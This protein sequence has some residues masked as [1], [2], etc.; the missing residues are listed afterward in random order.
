M[1]F[2]LSAFSIMISGI[3]ILTLKNDDQE[4]QKRYTNAGISLL[5]LSIIVFITTL[6]YEKR[7]LIFGSG[8]KVC[9]YKR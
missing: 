7:K 3:Y 8:C 5:I 9:R 1:I 4:I 2:Y 6:T